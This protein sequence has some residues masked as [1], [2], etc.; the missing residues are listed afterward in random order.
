[1]SIEA[2]LFTAL[3]TNSG[4]SSLVGSRIYPSRAPDSAQRPLI[5]YQLV[6]GTR[7]ATLPGV[8]DA[9]KKRIQVSCHA[10]TYSAAKSVAAA[11]ISALEGNGYLELELDLH[12]PTTQS[13]TVVV[14]WSFMSVS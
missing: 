12:D 6:A 5:V 4:V 9:V 1:M 13:H 10:D 7:V 14:D 2:E 8:G 3:S 11:V